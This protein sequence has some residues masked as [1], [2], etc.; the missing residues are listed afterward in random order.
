VVSLDALTESNA[1]SALLGVSIRLMQPW[2][3]DDYEGADQAR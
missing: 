2:I 1:S 3:T